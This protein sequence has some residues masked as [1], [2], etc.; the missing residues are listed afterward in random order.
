MTDFSLYVSRDDRVPGR[1]YGMGLEPLHARADVEVRFLPP[2]DYHE[3]RTEDLRGADAVIT[4]EDLVT[5][6]TLDGL[7]GLQLVAAFG[8]GMDHLALDAITERGIPVVNSPQ[9][10]RD[11]V[12]QTTLGMLITCASNSVRYNNLVREQGFESRF[13]NMGAALYGK[14]LGI[15]G[16]GMIGSRVLDLVAPF[17]M[18][19][20]THDPY[21]DEE[22]AA[23]LGVER[24]DLDTLL[25]ESDF[26]SLHCPLTD[27][28][29]GMLGT[30]QFRTMKET[31]Y[32]VNTTRGGIYP[33]A[34]LA[35]AVREGWIA[36]AAIDVFEDEPAVEGNPLLDL[37]DCLMTPHAAGVLKDTMERQGNMASEAILAVLD[38]EIPHNLVNPEVY[39]RPVDPD[40]LSPSHRGDAT[41]DHYRG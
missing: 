36:G 3:L 4:I 1:D 25:R 23:E 5:E 37:E 8:A 16:M 6:D 39:D 26:V 7:N 24:V 10:P 22:R 27:E 35:E 31:A 14:T 40:L 19:V 38:G 9:G 32:I 41:D 33:D 13:E 30:E 34:E 15:I 20:L 12:A 18:E 2:R 21:L 29:R 11:A 28:T 17:E